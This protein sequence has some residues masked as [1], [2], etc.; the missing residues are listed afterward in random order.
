MSERIVAYLRDGVAAAI[1]QQP[2]ATAT[3]RA[4]VTVSATISDGTATR[5]AQ[6]PAFAVAGPG[7]VTALHASQIASR[8]PAPDAMHAPSD[9]FAWIEFER[10]DLPWLFTPYG[11][12]NERLQPWLC[13]LVIRADRG[14]LVQTPAGWKLKLEPEAAGELPDL[15]QAH[16][17]AHAHVSTQSA[18]EVVD[19][20]VYRRQPAAARSRLVCPRRLAGDTRYVACLVPTFKASVLA[21]LGLPVAGVTNLLAPAWSSPITAPLELPLYAHWHFSTGPAGSFEELVRSLKRPASLAG[22]GRRDLDATSPGGGITPFAAQVT[23][24]MDGALQPE[25]A[26]ADVPHPALATALAGRL[27]IAGALCPPT[28]GQWHAA[29]RVGTPGAPAWLAELNTNAIRRVAAG[30]GTQVVQRHQEMLMAACWEQA[31]EIL[32]ANQHRRI[33]EAALA[34]SRSLHRRRL[35]PWAQSGNLALAAFA[36]PA[37]PRLPFS[38]GQT[39][40]GALRGTCL[41][42]LALSGAMQKL[43]RPSGPLQRR[44][45]RTISPDAGRPIAPETVYAALANDSAPDRAPAPGGARLISVS[46][47]R[48]RRLTLTL[49]DRFATILDSI[50]NRRT[51]VAVPANAGTPLDRVLDDFESVLQSTRRRACT[52]LPADTN[53]SFVETLWT[54]LDPEVTI[55][56]RVNSRLRI[57]TGMPA[58]AG[59]MKPILVAPRLPVATAKLLLETSPEW[60]LP[61]IGQLEP[62]SIV[63]FEPDHAFIESFMV[64]LNHEMSRELLW[65]GFPTD[66]RGTVFDSFWR[67]DDRVIGPLHQWRRALGQ[68]LASAT[69]DLTVLLIRGEL[70]RRF[71]A[72]TVFLQKKDPATGRPVSTVGGTDTVMPVFSQ[73]LDPDVRLIG[74]PRAMTAVRGDGT[75]AS[76]GYYLAFQEEPKTLRFGPATGLAEHAYA[77]V[78]A[79]ADSVLFAQQLRRPPARIYQPAAALV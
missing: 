36:M 52:P 24:K 45:A 8:W 68:H 73:S 54:A 16:A 22:I 57:P 69:T 10:G 12:T 58:A 21:G 72:A 20:T 35:L 59:G 33:A 37:L 23:L 50:L 3:V 66:Q 55:P 13:L 64:G 34:T 49:R 44:I 40:H 47:L 25:R 70:V 1:T 48:G 76:P 53:G 74:F 42:P 38:A 4:A 28:Y 30:L 75:A 39:F 19:E 31:G 62:E 51:P 18:A 56:A 17:W 41:T 14:T 60:L 79:D 46:A 77:V 71:P 9:E 63:L 27:N 43:L 5:Q 11:P 61:G 2:G 7:D 67:T 29:S 26:P 65:R 32:R 78:P 15:A 6:P